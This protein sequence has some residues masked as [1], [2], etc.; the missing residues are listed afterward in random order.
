MKPTED[1]APESE[2]LF[3]PTNL[4]LKLAKKREDVKT[5]NSER[6][7]ELGGEINDAVEHKHLDKTAHKMACQLRALSDN[8]LAITL[9]HLM[10][11]IDDMKLVERAKKQAE[12]FDDGKEPGEA[13][14]GGKVTRLG[15][16]ARKVAEAA[17]AQTQ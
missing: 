2:M 11:Y 6:A 14:G 10:R 3:P 15:T 16:A 5:D 9:P 12:M 17:G 4:V 8:K 7:G 13:A 1:A